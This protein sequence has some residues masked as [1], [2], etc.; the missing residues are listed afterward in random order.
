[1]SFVISTDRYNITEKEFQLLAGTGVMEEMLRNKMVVEC[2]DIKQ[3]DRLYEI[4]GQ[5]ATSTYYINCNDLVVT[6]YYANPIDR[7]RLENEL[8]RI[9]TQGL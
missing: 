1:M 4:A 5:Y 6:I 9:I 2:R 3:L 8:T 7:N